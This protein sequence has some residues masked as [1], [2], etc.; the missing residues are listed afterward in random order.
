M[1]GG[2]PTSTFFPEDGNYKEA[3]LLC[4]ACEVKRECLE[5]AISF[6]EDEYGMFGG[7]TPKERGAYKWQ[8]HRGIRQN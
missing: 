3:R 4:A 5:Y 1:C 8:K 7:M 6:D 2:V